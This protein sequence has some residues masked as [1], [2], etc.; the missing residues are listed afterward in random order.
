[1]ADI[2]SSPVRNVIDPLIC[3]YSEQTEGMNKIASTPNH[4]ATKS[5][6]SLNMKTTKQRL[7]SNLSNTDTED[8]KQNEN[9]ISEDR[10]NINRNS[11]HHENIQDSNSNDNLSGNDG[12]NGGNGGGNSAASILGPSGWTPFLSRTTQP[13]SILSHVSTPSS[14]MF[15]TLYKQTQSLLPSEFDCASL[16]LTPFLAHNV[17]LIQQPGGPNSASQNV[18]FTPLCD[19]SLHLADFFMDSPI[20][21]TPR[22]VGSITPSRFTIAPDQRSTA[23]GDSQLLS[24][25]SLKRSITLI[26]TPARQPFKKMEQSVESMED[27]DDEDLASAE[28]GNVRISV[29]D[30]DDLNIE[31]SNSYGELYRRNSQVRGTLRDLP[32]NTMNKTPFRNGSISKAKLQTPAHPVSSPSTVI[33]SSVTKSPE[34]GK[35]L[36]PASPTPQK[37][38]KGDT[39][40]PIMGIFS[41][42]KPKMG[43]FQD[44][45]SSQSSGKKTQKKPQANMNRFQ[46][47]FTDV[48]TLM[49]SKKKKSTNSGTNGA[50]ISTEKS[51]KGGDRKQK[52]KGKDELANQAPQRSNS[53]KF[54]PRPSF[55]NHNSSQ[56]TNST[57]STHSTHSLHSSQPAQSGQTSHSVHSVHSS[58]GPPPTYANALS[59]NF[60]TSMNSSRE[61]SMMNNSTI[62]TTATTNFTTADQSSFD[63]M[64]GGLISTPN[65]KYL[66]DLLFEKYSP[67]MN[68]H[69]I[70]NKFSPINEHE[71][72]LDCIHPDQKAYMPPPKTLTLQQAAQNALRNRHQYLDHGVNNS[73]R[74][75]DTRGMDIRNM[76]TRGMDNYNSQQ[77][78]QQHQQ[79]Q[80][81]QE[82]IHQMSMIHPDLQSAH[83]G[84]DMQIPKH[85]HLQE[86]FQ[87]STPQHSR[88]NLSSQSYMRDNNQSSPS[89][90]ELM[91]FLYHQLEDYL[92]INIPN[93]AVG[94]PSA[95]TTSSPTQSRLSDKGQ[96]RR[97]RK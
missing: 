18:N 30:D 87:V 65:G 40:E 92:Q 59:Q 50:S 90:K 15:S 47:V 49:N 78:Q 8:G 38:I 31:N 34:K 79:Q 61:F 68:L 9:E 60:N 71:Q 4:S 10:T 48:H 26:D 39:T 58:Q 44:V 73:G 25:L 91:A 14:K 43:S 93:Q 94:G 80:Q 76:D 3:S 83:P 1:M 17:N 89:N 46:I 12:I 19:K 95:Y 63:L 96:R 42:R 7:T 13:D 11:H 21:Q 33:M 2:M 86:K 23:H 77:H 66:Q 45:K 56:S 69:M 70:S 28:I 75:M 64:Q 74:I 35:L 27:E 29:D 36:A 55:S 82:Q 32:S 5:Q 52:K 85:Q 88:H 16:N 84:L 20:R 22:K 53:G 57:H 67:N 54:S 72:N 41:E 51:D 62:N 37:E 97:Q 81:Q 24:E 6:S